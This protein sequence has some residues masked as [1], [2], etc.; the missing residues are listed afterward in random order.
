MESGDLCSGRPNFG[1]IAKT[2][3]NYLLSLLLLVR[4]KK[5]SLVWFF[6]PRVPN[7]QEK[8][9]LKLCEKEIFLSLFRCLPFEEQ[10]GNRL[11][12]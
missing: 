11:F 12:R 4:Q 3:S 10:N 6:L 1:Y 7:I 9:C 5:M 8:F 2:V